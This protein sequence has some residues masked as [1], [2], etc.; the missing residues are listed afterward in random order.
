[1]WLFCKSGFFSA[2]QHLD[3]AGVIELLQHRLQPGINIPSSQ[4][5]D[6]ILAVVRK[7]GVIND[8][9]ALLDNAIPQSAC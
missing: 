8:D 5:E 4:L 9:L 7:H 3:N 2:V 6:K 1:M